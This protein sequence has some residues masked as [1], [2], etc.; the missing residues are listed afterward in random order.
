MGFGFYGRSFQLSD[1][2]CSKPGCEFKGGA[3]AGPCSDTSGILM[4]YEIMSLMKQHP[5]L[6][7]IYDKNAG[8]K[9]LVF[10][11][12]QWVSYD[13]AETFKQKKEWANNIGLGGSLI[14]ASDAG[15]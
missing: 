11:K 15:K 7:P 5:E 10:N 3:E 14:W 12:D 2:S 4:Y 6:K 1:P 13:D 8:V 9:Y